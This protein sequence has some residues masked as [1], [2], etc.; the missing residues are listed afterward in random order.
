MAQVNLH[1][2]LSP[3]Q[4]HCYYET[5]QIFATN[6]RLCHMNDLVQCPLMACIFEEVL[7]L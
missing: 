3:K 1:N 4:M 6:A 2:I 7:G 5:G